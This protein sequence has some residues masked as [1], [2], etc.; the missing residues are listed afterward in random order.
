MTLR[1]VRIAALLLAVAGA[2]ALGAQDLQAT[3]DATPAGG[4]LRLAPGVH[5]GPVVISRP[6]V[7]AGSSGATIDGGGIGTVLTIRASGTAVRGLRIVNSGNLHDQTDAAIRVEGDGNVIENNLMENVLFG[8]VLQQANGN[9]VRANHIRSRH[10]DPADRGDAVRLWYSFGNRIADNDIADARDISLISSQRNRITGNTVRNG[11]TGLHMIFAG[12]TLI[13]GNT[14]SYNSGGIFAL[15]SEGLIIRDNRIL[16]ATSASGSGIGLKETSSALIEGND[17]VHC[18]VG[19]LADSPTHPVNRIVI[20]DNHIAHCLTGIVFYGEKGGHIV[21][22]N[23]FEHNLSHAVTGG[24]GDALANDWYGNYWDDYGGFD[25]NH[26]GVGDTPY[27][28]YAYADRIWMGEPKAKF[29]NNTPLMKLIDFL[30]HLAPFSAPDLIL[31][32]PA[33]RAH[34]R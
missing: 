2:H 34:R 4:T 5:A 14:F 1:V 21:H 16:H 24:F 25:R 28:L 12:R 19:I 23:R 7:I 6:I 9:V 13:K 10:R 27:E 17:I 33:P 18:G 26:D 29:F 15:N 30:E 20:I 8:I 32:D 22:R 31:R 3:I 11:R